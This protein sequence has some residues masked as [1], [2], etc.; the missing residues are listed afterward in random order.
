MI[1]PF[2]IPNRWIRFAAAWRLKF[3]QKEK[4][5]VQLPAEQVSAAVVCKIALK[6]VQIWNLKNPTG[7]LNQL[8]F[9]FRRLVSN[10]NTS[11]IRRVMMSTGGSRV[12][13]TEF[14]IPGC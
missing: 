9:D 14:H 3:P 11:G 13:F 6:L 8:R 7:T 10:L 12:D 2:G 4:T 1:P 5:H